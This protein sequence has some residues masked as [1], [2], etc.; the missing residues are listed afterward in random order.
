MP[1]SQRWPDSVG[2]RLSLSDAQVQLCDIPGYLSWTPWGPDDWVG[3][4]MKRKDMM[5]IDNIFPS[6]TGC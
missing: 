3:K 5:P 6:G 1:M 4:F 2:V